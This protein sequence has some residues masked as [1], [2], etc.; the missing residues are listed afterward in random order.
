MSNFVHFTPDQLNLSSAIPLGTGAISNVLHSTLAPPLSIPVAIK[1]Y[2]KVQLLQLCKVQSVMNEKQALLR[3]RSHPYIGRLYGTAQSEDELYAVMELLTNGDLLQHIRRTAEKRLREYSIAQPRPMGR[4]VAG[5]EG[6]T[7][8]RDFRLAAD[9]TQAAPPPPRSGGSAGGIPASSRALRCLDFQDIQLITA[10]IILGLSHV[11]KNGLV[12]RDL[13]PENIVFDGKCRACLIDFDTVDLEGNRAKP[14]TNHGVALPA[15]R[16]SMTSFTN[17]GDSGGLASRPP[18]RSIKVS[19]IQAM[20]RR[21]ASFCGTA[22]YVSP[23]MVGE[24][25]W[26]FSSD[27]WSL[28]T[29]VY[30]MLYG[31]HMF[32]G[33]T[34]FGV[35]KN[36][37][38]GVAGGV[39]GQAAVPF[40]IV[41][42]G[43]RG[44]E[45]SCP[46]EEV[47]PS[48]H[49]AR[50]KDF[51]LR[52]VDIDPFQ[53]LGV[54]PETHEFDLEALKRHSLFSNFDWSLVENQIL[55]FKQRTFSMRDGAVDL[56]NVATSEVLDP[57]PSLSLQCFYQ[58]V[59]YND[60]RYAEYIYNA[61]SEGNPFERYLQGIDLGS[62]IVEDTKDGVDEVDHNQNDE[63]RCD[64]TS[65]RTTLFNND[66]VVGES[67]K[68][69]SDCLPS[70][71]IV[72]FPSDFK[73]TSCSEGSSAC[74]RRSSS[75]D[76]DDES[77]E[78]I[79]DVGMRFHALALDPDFRN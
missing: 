51:I 14:H 69:T 8:G 20:R 4:P 18:K 10:Q 52:L 24:C 31:V 36:V 16:S 19:E 47:A 49:F 32:A 37:I 59:P 23:E 75:I 71:E 42:L 76:T 35:M 79:D 15:K 11:F 7:E 43:R 39:N 66:G 9:Q 26:S 48:D 58:E 5:E 25:R 50:V 27:L 22:Q 63:L 34:S 13:K 61:S 56:D 1:V 54:H 46:G 17:K 3:L 62:K 78:V 41:D 29:I 12:M 44:N 57:D 70:G 65:A 40:P 60:R 21:T 45:A 33:M 64:P 73:Q 30:E 77:I 38:K 2:S 72:G 28:G 6:Q 53:R 55:T 68:L 67:S 74:F